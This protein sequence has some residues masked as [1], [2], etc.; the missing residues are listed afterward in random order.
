MDFV[1]E[2][3]CSTVMSFLHELKSD[4]SVSYTIPSA[5]NCLVTSNSGNSSNTMMSTNSFLHKL[6]S[7]GGDIHARPQAAHGSVDSVSGYGSTA[8]GGT[9]TN[10]QQLIAQ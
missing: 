5:S 1:S 3:S 6:E 10:P 8:F 2:N 7:F 9:Y 4:S